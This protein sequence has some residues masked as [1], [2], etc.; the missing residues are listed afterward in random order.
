MRRVDQGKVFFE[1][2]TCGHE[3]QADPNQDFQDCPQCGSRETRR[4]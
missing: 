2:E 1:C 3:F 4:I